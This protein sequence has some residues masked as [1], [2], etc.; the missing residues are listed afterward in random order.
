[1]MSL[2]TKQMAWNTLRVD[3]QWAQILSIQSNLT[4]L[5]INKSN[6]SN[7]E[8]E[9]LLKTKHAKILRGANLLG[10]VFL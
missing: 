1:M 2:P 4:Y 5:L 10:Y 6:T 9:R 8:G 7:A 3:L